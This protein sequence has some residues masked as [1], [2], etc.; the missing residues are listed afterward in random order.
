MKVRFLSDSETSCTAV[1]EGISA[2]FANALRRV[3]MTEIPVYA[4]KDIIIYENSG[5]LFDEVIA[6]RIG[7]V[8]L[9]TPK[10]SSEDSKS[11]IISIDVAGPSMVT[12]ADFVSEDPDVVP[13]SDGFPIVKIGKGQRLKCNIEGV[14]GYGKD[15]TRW[16][17]GLASY[18]NYPSI[19]ID[20]VQCNLCGSCIKACPRALIQK[21]GD[22]LT[23]V[24]AGSCMFCRACEEACAQ[25]NEKS[26][27]SVTPL[28]DVFIF[29]VESY[30]AMPAKDLLSTALMVI[31]NKARA[32]D[33][34]LSGA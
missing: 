1:I 12:S 9:T 29:M 16:Q 15:H 17:P 27:I 25:S 23:V 11:V 7:L 32:L 2:P 3:I 33:Q 14:V 34:N 30:G 22:V 28:K 4:G 5:P 10:D 18:K 24:D 6:H 13:T 19:V 26:L 31:E 8:P 21:D 20:T